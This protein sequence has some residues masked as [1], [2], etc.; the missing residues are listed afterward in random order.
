MKE[1]ALL[2]L[3][4][5][6]RNRMGSNPRTMG[7]RSV[8]LLTV[9][10]LA[11]AE[12]AWRLAVHERAPARVHQWTS[13]SKVHRTSCPS[14]GMWGKKGPS[15]LVYSFDTLVSQLEVLPWEALHAP[16]PSP[17]SQGDVM[18]ALPKAYVS[19]AIPVADIELVPFEDVH[20]PAVRFSQIERWGT[21]GL[22]VGEWGAVVA[23]R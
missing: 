15:R 21:E 1:S 23:R 7:A 3:G 20:D 13:K 12:E 6:I 17:S 18:V 9:P 14:W 22:V 8:G 10:S 11:V 5:G 4:K 2:I 19:E 16:H